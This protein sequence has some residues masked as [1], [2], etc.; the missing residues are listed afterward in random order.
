M[1]EKIRGRKAASRSKSAPVE[2]YP[3]KRWKRIAHAAFLRGMKR[4][5]AP[6]HEVEDWRNAEREI[7]AADRK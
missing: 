4:G 3:E 1:A 7:D 2:S 6:G 5:F